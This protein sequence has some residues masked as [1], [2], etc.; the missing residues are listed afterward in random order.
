M[1]GNR[2]S[3]QQEPP[4][5]D[6]AF[7]PE[8]LHAIQAGIATTL[9]P[10]RDGWRVDYFRVVDFEAEP[11]TTFPTF[12]AAV[13]AITEVLP[14]INSDEERECAREDLHQLMRAPVAAQSEESSG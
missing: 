10:V 2:S 4:E 1:R 6:A 9:M 3:D 11:G 5:G 12:E 14:V 8:Q 7:T 13:E